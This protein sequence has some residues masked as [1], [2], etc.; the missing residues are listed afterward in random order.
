M[1]NVTTTTAIDTF[2]Q[3]ADASAMRTNLGLGDSATKAVGTT[4]GTVAAGDDSRIVGAVQTT[5]S[6]TAGTGLSGGGTL[7][8]DR[9]LSVS[10]GTTAGTA[11]QGNDSRLSN[12]RTPSG[13]ASGDL[14]GTYPSPLVSGLYNRP[15][16]SAAP[17]T[18]QVLG[19]NGTQWTP[20]TVSGSGT[21]ETFPVL[22]V[23]FEGPVTNQS[24]QVP[25][26]YRF[27]D[28]VVGTGGDGGTSG[29][30]RSMNDA[31]SYNG[32]T[33]GNGGANGVIR[34]LQ[35]VY[36]GGATISMTLGA[37]GAGGVGSQLNSATYQGQ[38]SG[39]MGGDAE[40]WISPT[41]AG[42]TMP[43]HRLIKVVRGDINRHVEMGIGSGGGFNTAGYSP[44]VTNWNNRDFALVA[45]GG[46]GGGAVNEY[47]STGAIAGGAL[48]DPNGFAFDTTGAAM[49][50]NGT[51]TSVDAATTPKISATAEGY[52]FFGF[53]GAGG[54]GVYA[55]YPNNAFTRGGDG[56]HGN[57]GCGGGG[58]GGCLVSAQ[59]NDPDGVGMRAG[60][61][62]NGGPAFIL[63]MLR[64]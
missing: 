1:A 23:M 22:A 50:Y 2:M 52:N 59:Q 32:A 12:S 24:Y 3:S 13:T 49:V 11:C 31:Q 25:S 37:G 35:N 64:K 15:L 60:S 16:A 44:Q 45:P 21:S 62:G 29:D 28:V 57:P 30:I 14:N 48:G 19:W 61:G 26:G 40:V 34:M 18:G 56:G 17:T 53:G 8:E 42:Y 5:R 38:A 6:I 10:Y 9:T 46:G 33:G 55:N 4:S 58:G 63:L 27:A 43:A 36:V 54:A 7:A 39:G 41:A 47:D 20:M 51:S